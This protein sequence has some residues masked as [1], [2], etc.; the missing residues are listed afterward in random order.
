V[1]EPREVVACSLFEAG[2]E[3]PVFRRPHLGDHLDD[4]QECDLPVIPRR[5]ACGDVERWLVHVR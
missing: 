4:V 3:L 2:V 5:E 1:A